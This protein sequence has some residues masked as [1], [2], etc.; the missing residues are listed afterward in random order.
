M[1][2]LVGV[3]RAVD[4]AARWHVDQRR[5][6]AA[7]EPYINHLIEVAVLVAEATGGN[8]V[9]LVIAALL[10]DAIEDCGVTR[11]LIAA[12]FGEDVAAL[13]AEVTD[14]KSIPKADRKR[15]Q[16]ETAASKSVGA[17]I[18]KLADKTSNLT[19]I[20]LS[21]PAAWSMER[22]QEYIRWAREVA[23]GAR[24]ANP[25]LESQF[26]QAAVAAERA[27]S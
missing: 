10:H 12:K 18:I 24:G 23:E 16:V 27:S 21:P 22:R 11:E 17:K 3:L 19:A 2:E 5:K 6:G 14:D 20:A 25:H 1:K 9:N 13:V 4:A 7:A 26:E 8:D 15:R